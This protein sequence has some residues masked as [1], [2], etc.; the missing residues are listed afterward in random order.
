MQL[1]A[2]YQLRE[3]MISGEQ[4]VLNDRLKSLILC[5][6]CRNHL[7]VHSRMSGPRQ[8]RPNDS[9]A[10]SSNFK[11]QNINVYEWCHCIPECN[12][13]PGILVTTVHIISKTV[14]PSWYSE[15]PLLSHVPLCDY[16]QVLTV[17]I[18]LHSVALV[19]QWQGV[20]L[21]T[22]RSWVWFPIW[23]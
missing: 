21:P 22:Y 12:L 1:H 2:A 20:R 6:G 23:T 7:T 11:W 5:D 17:F 4:C 9:A 3:Y 15:W 16:C 10:Q 19:A 14:C 18:C 13:R 8:R